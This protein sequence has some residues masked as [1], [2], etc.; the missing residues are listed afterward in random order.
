MELTCNAILMNSATALTG[1]IAE[2][3]C[4]DHLLACSVWAPYKP[5]AILGI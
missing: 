5:V 1:G 4:L 3:P 2:S